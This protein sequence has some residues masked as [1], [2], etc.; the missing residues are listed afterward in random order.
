MVFSEDDNGNYRAGGFLINKNSKPLVTLPDGLAVPTGLFASLKERKPSFL[1]MET[2]NYVIEPSIC[3]Y[4]SSQVEE[5]KKSLKSKESP[6]K[7]TK[8][9]TKR[10]KN[11]KSRTKI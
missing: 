10:T 9:N 8:R 11:K 6:K 7:M 3:D 2:S 1:N 5:S 4:L